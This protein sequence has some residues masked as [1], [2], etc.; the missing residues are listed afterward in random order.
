MRITWRTVG[1]MITRVR[2]GVEA[3]VD[4]FAGLRRIGIDEISHKKGQRYLTVVVDHDSGRLVWAGVG[5]TKDTLRGFFDALAAS[6][7]TGEDRCAQISL[8][9]A[10][11]A[12]WIADVV[13]ERCVNAV[14]G[15]R[16]RSMSSNGPPSVRR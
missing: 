10:D 11:G 12:G 16:T 14:R 3:R 15:A 13:A 2:A 8:A 7:P 6:S 9:S 4:L 1:A 5:R